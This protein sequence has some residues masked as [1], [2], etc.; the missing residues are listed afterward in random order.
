MARVDMET[1]DLPPHAETENCRIS[2]PRL[3]VRATHLRFSVHYGGFPAVTLRYM[4]TE[5]S[6]QGGKNTEW[7]L[8]MDTTTQHKSC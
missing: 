1:A 5:Q 7:K 2:W 4:D 6:E 3:S 8:E